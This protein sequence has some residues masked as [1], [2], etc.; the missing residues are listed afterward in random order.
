MNKE[1]TKDFGFKEWQFSEERKRI[2]K[3]SGKIIAIMRDAVDNDKMPAAE[4][5]SA[6][7][8]V[9]AQYS[10]TCNIAPKDFEKTLQMLARRYAQFVHMH[11]TESKNE[12]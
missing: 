4:I 2:H 1:N 3:L 9:I 6:L 10:F 7:D 12:K 5:L 11:A 8:S